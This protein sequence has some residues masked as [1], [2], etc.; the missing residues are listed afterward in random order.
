MLIEKLYTVQQSLVVV[1]FELS[2]TDCNV[3]FSKGVIPLRKLKDKE[4]WVL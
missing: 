1:A 4:N 2:L 3:V